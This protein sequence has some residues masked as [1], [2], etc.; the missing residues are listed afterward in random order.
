MFK[1]LHQMI[2]KSFNVKNTW[3]GPKSHSICLLKKK[4]WKPLYITY[5]NQ[6][7]PSKND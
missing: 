1:L 3:K 7:T 2:P 5:F 6:K 4:N